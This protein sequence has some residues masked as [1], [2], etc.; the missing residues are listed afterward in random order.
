[1]PQRSVHSAS[2]SVGLVGQE[3]LCS[4]VPRVTSFSSQWCNPVNICASLHTTGKSY[5]QRAE[6]RLGVNSHW[7]K[8][9]NNPYFTSL[10]LC[11]TAN[12]LE[13]TKKVHFS[14]LGKV[15]ARDSNVWGVVFILYCCGGWMGYYTFQRL[16]WNSLQ[17]GPKREESNSPSRTYQVSI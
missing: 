3:Y 16:S 6:R 9:G 15:E 13:L 2:V 12:V 10:S 8:R 14:D 4:F 17:F 11:L 7:Y 1:M 5:P